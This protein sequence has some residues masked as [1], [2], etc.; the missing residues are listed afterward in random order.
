[1]FETMGGIVDFAALRFCGFCRFFSPP[2]SH[3]PK[4]MMCALPR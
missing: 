1:V 4:F 3:P 2:R